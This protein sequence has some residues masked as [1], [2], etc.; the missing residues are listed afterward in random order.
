MFSFPKNKRKNIK[1]NCRIISTASYV[2][3]NILTNDDIINA[4]N[5]TISKNVIIKTLGVQER[6][7][8]NDKEVDSDLLSRSAE[9]CLKKAAISPDSLSRLIVTKFIGDNLLPMTASMV[10]R[11]IGCTMTV[12]SFDIEG[13][14]S[15]FLYAS[16]MAIRYINSGDEYVLIT[17]GGICNSIISKTDPR[18]AFLFGDGA[19]AV[20][21]SSCEEKHF[22][23]SYLYTN[24]NYY[25]LARS[26]PQNLKLQ[27]D[28][29][30]KGDF[31]VFYDFYHMDNWKIAEEFYKQATIAIRDSL[32]DE[33]G[34]KMSDID[35][36][37]ATENNKKI[38]ELTLDVLEVPYDKSISMIEHYG[39]TMSAMLPLLIDNGFSTGKIEKD[40]NIMLISHGEGI[41]GGGM[42][43]KV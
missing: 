8:A 5:L 15:S 17:S 11:K 40:M 9:K 43:Y 34:L 36:V 38:W 16:D 35:L 1:K 20:L 19:A 12:H 10:Q 26:S 18:V 42:I 25:E 41:S 23:A 39:N 28:F 30:N 14:I 27:D 29:F 37:L 7:V 13:G 32:L 22:R 4:G 24:H 31:S 2:P 21:L 6:R 3:Q 33:S